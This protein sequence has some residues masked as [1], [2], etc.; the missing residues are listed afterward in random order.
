VK[1]YSD[2][3]TRTCKEC[4]KDVVGRKKWCPDCEK[5]LGNARRRELYRINGRYSYGQS[6][7]PI[8]NLPMQMW[9][10]SQASHNR[11]REKIVENYNR[12]SRAK[13][14]NTVGRETIINLGIDIPKGWVVHHLDENPENNNPSNLLV[15]SRSQ[16]NKLHRILQYHRLLFLKENSHNPE[17]CWNILRDHLTKAWLETAG[18]NVIKTD[19]IGQ[20]AAESLSSEE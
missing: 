8:C 14:G 15:T 1:G 5:R 12:V 19:D 4:G 20:S 2:L 10:K 9:R 6:V 16:H 3:K 17:N 13:S 7:C 18:A 11:C